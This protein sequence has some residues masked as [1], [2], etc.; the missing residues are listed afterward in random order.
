MKK[1]I[2]L[3][4]LVLGILNVRAEVRD[5]EPTNA[6]GNVHISLLV[7]NRFVTR[8]EAAYFSGTIVNRSTNV[9]LLFREVPMED[10]YAILS[11]PSGKR[12]LL[13]PKGGA[14]GSTR[15]L[16]VQAG[17]SFQEIFRTVIPK[18]IE[19]GEYN[20]RAVRRV[21]I[22]EKWKDMESNAVQVQVK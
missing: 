4:A 1:K 11:A 10:F 9:V 3:L 15:L 6:V 18:N 13:K 16:H 19:P 14:G 17:S 2:L 22:G 7:T 8:E 12:Y 20:L 5:P 21:K